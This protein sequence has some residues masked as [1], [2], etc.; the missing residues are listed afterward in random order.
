MPEFSKLEIS[1]D[2]KSI[3][4]GTSGGV[5][6]LV[7]A[8]NGGVKTRLVDHTPNTISGLSS[9]DVCF[10]PDGRFVMGGTL[11]SFPRARLTCDTATGDSKIAVWDLQQP[12]RDRSLSTTHKLDA[13][14]FGPLNVLAI[15]PRSAL[16]T[17]AST[18]LVNHCSDLEIDK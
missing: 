5:H 4:V 7:D 9:G 18:E 3:L 2:G 8:F 6:Y 11:P 13:K 16:L 15:N 12:T 14:A 10:T 17:T 1:N